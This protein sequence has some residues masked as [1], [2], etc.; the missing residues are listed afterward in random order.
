VRPCA[1]S[2]LIVFLCL[3]VGA[4]PVDGHVDET[5]T[6]PVDDAH[7]DP[8]PRREPT[9]VMLRG[10]PPGADGEFP[11]WQPPDPRWAH[12]Y[13]TPRP[14]AYHFLTTFGGPGHGDHQFSHPRGMAFSPDGKKLAISDTDNH[15]IV[16]CSVSEDPLATQP[17]R[18]ELIM[19]GLW[20]WE[21]STTP[22]DP[23]DAY[24][25]RDHFDGIRPQRELPGRAYHGGQGRV[26]PG[27]AVPMDRFMYPEGVTWLGPDLLV[28]ADTGNHRVKAVKMTGEVAWVL[29]QEGWKDGYFHR[30]LGVACTRDGG[31]LVTEPRGKYIRG[32]GLDLLQRHRVQGNRIQIFAAKDLKVEKRI[33]DMHHVSGRFLAQYKD[34]TRVWTCRDGNIFIS[35]NGNHRVMVLDSELRHKEVLKSWPYVRL[36]YP[37]GIHGST[38]G[39]LLIAD[40]GNHRVLLLR[41]DRTLG[42]IFGGRAGTERG[43]FIKPFEAKFG[44][45]GDVYVLDT[46]NSRIQIFRGPHS[47]EADCPGKPAP[48]PEPEPAPIPL[49][50]EALPDPEPAFSH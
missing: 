46:Y 20:P 1:V 38:D 36:R 50:P 32:L 35:D 45:T 2:L 10:L 15:R 25:E 34:P 41:P 9:G 48:A 31:L 47:K 21:G 12:Q 6:F 14:D 11:P 42:Q 18:V 4:F 33:G 49:P 16:L 23:P 22:R 28:I 40:T 27:A 8:P 39:R 24:R 17:L 30:P 29:G 3:L 43:R 26:R 44:P 37:H 5:P 19:G 13:K 7:F